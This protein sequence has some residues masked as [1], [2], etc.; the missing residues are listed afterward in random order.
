MSQSGQSQREL[1]PASKWVARFMPSVREP[2]RERFA[3]FFGLSALLGLAQ[4]LGLA[5]S[6][7]L[8]LERVGPEALAYVFV[9]APVITVLGCLAYA[10]V[11]GQQRN[12]DLFAKIL[13]LAGGVLAAGTG[14]AVWGTP[15]VFH[16]LF[17]A[18]YLTQ[19]VLINLHF[20]TFA[21]DFFD[22]LQSKRLYPHLVV[23]ASGGGV[24]GGAIAALAGVALPAEA[25]IALW[26]VALLSGAFMVVR[27]RPYLRR[28]RAIG[29]EE[30][31]E[32][33]TSGL[34]GGLR[35]LTRS[36]LAMWL[37]ISIVGMISSLFLLQY[38]YL[39]IFSESFDSAETLAVFLGSY[40]AISNGIE[41]LT[42]TVVTPWLLQRFG[43]PTA[44]LV[45]PVLTVAVFPVVAANPALFPAVLARV[46][47][48]LLEN[49]IAAPIRQLAYNALP[50]RFRGR[51]RALLE[52]VV[53]F[54]AMAFAGGV[55]LVI[56]DEASLEVL[57]GLGM[58]T[59][60]AYVAASFAVRRAYLSSLVDEL[61][62]GRLDLH[63]MDAG[64]GTAGMAN[65]AEQW[66]RI[67][68]EDGPT[69]SRSVLRFARDLAE[70]GF[71]EV[72]VHA[73]HH[74]DPRVREACIEA[75]LDF[76]AA[77]L[78]P[79]LERLLDDADSQV[80]LTTLRTLV[81]FPSRSERI[82]V[83]LQ[84]SLEDGD[85]EVRAAAAY[86]A[87]PLG[88]GTLR[89][90]LDTGDPA[91]IV[92]ALEV[93]PAELIALAI[94]ALDHE[95]AS[96]RAAA[97]HC[98]AREAF[99]APMPTA[100]LCE[101]MCDTDARV[102]AAAARALVYAAP[103][104][105]TGAAVAST[106]IT[107]P[108]DHDHSG[109]QDITEVLVEA[110]DD[111]ARTVR[112][113][114]AE[115]LAELG[116]AGIEA[117][118]TQVRHP[119]RWTAHAA[120]HATACA[121]DFDVTAPLLRA[122]RD[123]V[124][125]A[126]QLAAGSELAPEESNFTSRFTRV[127][128]ANAYERT[129]RG[130]FE[131]LAVVEAPRVVRSVQRALERGSSRNRADALEVLSHLA[132]R[133]ASGWFALLLEAGPFAEKRVALAGAVDLPGNFTD[134]L[135]H[136]EDQDDRWLRLAARVTLRGASDRQPDHTPGTPV[137]T[138]HSEVDL[139]Q[140][141]LALRKVPLFSELSLDR[142]EAIHQLMSETEFL[143]GEVVV[144]EGDAA[145]DLYVL[146][147]GELEIYKDHGT[148]DQ[149]LLNTQNPI[150]YMGE[151]AILDGSPRSATAIASKDSLLLRLGGE[152][153]K[154]IVLQ[155][156][157]ISFEIF[158]VLTARI[159]AAERPRD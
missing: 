75:L 65:L 59:G 133:E 8:F 123:C 12:D 115:A 19:A 117:A 74:R 76:D 94:P 70:H 124:R 78:E 40:L 106:T 14:L 101:A 34:R 71:G 129:I 83:H 102:R 28:W 108:E 9:A 96:V 51:V 85:P 144:R 33:S 60:V 105:T 136:L 81:E 90:L 99:D 126:W 3:F 23:G 21:A 110:L 36:R 47:R 135:D 26:S 24:A 20:W 156:P 87:G 146:I 25:L 43:V 154:E 2:E 69:P 103:I 149:R 120:L 54:A 11:V 97:I 114:A 52:G 80:R 112:L 139:M 56:A 140:S 72:V 73:S 104:S 15:F 5:G 125:E 39:G 122:Y 13:V 68:E 10:A 147:E 37:V 77:A 142:L 109:E 48:E 100:R 111:D 127:A 151:I 98:L 1:G 16:A 31:D 46:V 158:K 150:A 116:P 113:A 50:F 131:T 95:T 107:V 45:H 132:D 32:S 137:A 119:R 88:V 93:L 141:L 148:P 18:A 55:L 61:R 82:D 145:D 17:C 22:T 58:A 44:N 153:F 89:E 134:V 130:A 157:E 152:P 30:R 41:I 57:C 7:A 64:L 91:S 92:P 63:E 155:T 53:L 84:S 49:A 4:T 27:A 143:R 121:R 138:A 29:G 86:A 67:L 6:E 118:L 38:L 35:F 159:R 42:A 66:Q 79:H 128:L 62:R